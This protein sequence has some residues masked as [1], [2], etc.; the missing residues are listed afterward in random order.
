M[1][2]QVS[3]SQLSEEEGKDTSVTRPTSLWDGTLAA[4]AL[5]RTA[6][7]GATNCSSKSVG[8]GGVGVGVGVGEEAGSR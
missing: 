4:L 7:V 3:G 1:A 6:C 2:A 8:V 5:R